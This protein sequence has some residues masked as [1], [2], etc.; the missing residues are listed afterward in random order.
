MSAKENE[1]EELK[2]IH[3]SKSNEEHLRLEEKLTEKL[4]RLSQLT[5]EKANLETTITSLELVISERDQ[6]LN[7]LSSEKQQVNE[8]LEKLFEEKSQ[9]GKCHFLGNN[10]TKISPVHFTEQDVVT[11]KE[12]SENVSKELFQLRAENERQQQ[13]SSDLKSSLSGQYEQQI[14]TLQK[15]LDKAGDQHR[16]QEEELLAL[17]EEIHEKKQR[18]KQ[19]KDENTLLKSAGEQHKEELAKQVNNSQ[20]SSQ[21][22]VDLSIEG[23]AGTCFSSDN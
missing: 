21:T 18:V 15:A 12:N 16:A 3:A 13:Q 20:Q 22:S 7:K 14:E 9:L 4:E 19:L 10:S 23:K 2:E 1:L 5:T 17:K 8:Q 6:Q 11:A